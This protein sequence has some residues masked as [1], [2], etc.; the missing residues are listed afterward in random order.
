[1]LIYGQKSTHLLTNSI[2]SSCPH[3][4]SSNTVRISVFQKYAHVFWIPFFPLGKTGVSECSH[5]K[6][7][8]ELKEMPQAYKLDYEAIKINTKT[9]IWTF[10]GLVLLAGLITFGVYTGN[11]NEAENKQLINN[12]KVGDIYEYKTETKAYSTMKVVNV[13]KDSVAVVYNNF[14]VDRL[15]GMHKLKGSNAEYD[16]ISVFFHKSELAKKLESGEIIDVER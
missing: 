9:P 3:C 6:Q 8:L 10:I 12:P 7:V 5:C 1:M 14:E 11:K 4:N 16:S 13:T 15:K 2:K